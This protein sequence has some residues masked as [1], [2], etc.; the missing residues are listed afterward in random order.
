[1]P[2]A[3]GS[4]APDFALKDQNNFPVRLRDFRDRKAVLLVFYPL[5]FTG[6]CQGE[7]TGI[8]DNLGLYANDDVQVLA[9]SVDSAYSHKIWSLQEGFEFPLLADFWPHGEVAQRYEVFNATAGFANRGTFLID[10]TGVIVFSEEIGP[11]ESRDQ[12]AW[13]DAIAALKA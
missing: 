12:Q 13:Q 11:G 7:L 6:T 4:P 2:L 1:M 9:V 8:R 10:R 5:T 3:V